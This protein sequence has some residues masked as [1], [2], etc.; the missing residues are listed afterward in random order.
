M[1]VS[2]SITF[3]HGRD[4]GYWPQACII[5]IGCLKPQICCFWYWLWLISTATKKEILNWFWCLKYAPSV[6]D[7]STAN[8]AQVAGS[9]DKLSVFRPQLCNRYWQDTKRA[10]K[11]YKQ[12][13]QM[14]PRRLSLI[15]SALLAGAGTSRKRRHPRLAK[16][17]A[18]P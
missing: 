12:R 15:A 18:K 3:V 13:V 14:E 7:I 8:H 2:T 16:K 1:Y 5:Q 17:H 9:L 11:V 6:W 10:W 4:K